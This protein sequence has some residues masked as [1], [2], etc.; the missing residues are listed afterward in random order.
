MGRDAETTRR[1]LHAQIHAATLAR[2]RRTVNNSEKPDLR[3]VN[4]SEKPDLRMVNNSETPD[5][6][7]VNGRA[8]PG[9][10]TVDHPVDRTRACEV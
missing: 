2:K 6:R 9:S 1:E 10:G 4:N 5:L 8:K 7:M 3:M